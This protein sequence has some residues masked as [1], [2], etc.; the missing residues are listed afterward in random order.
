MSQG[1]ERKEQGFVDEALSLGMGSGDSIGKKALRMR[2][3]D[4]KG[5]H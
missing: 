1:K 4:S 3:S 5:C 2:D